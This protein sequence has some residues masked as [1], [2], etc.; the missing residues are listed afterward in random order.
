VPSFGESWHNNHHAF[1]TS[2]KFGLRWWEIDLGYIVIRSLNMIG[3]AWD[4]NYRKLK[5]SEMQNE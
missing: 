4:I 1:P 3:L 5:E 2:A